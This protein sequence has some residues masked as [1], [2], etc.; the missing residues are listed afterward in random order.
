MQEEIHKVLMQNMG[1]RLTPELINGLTARL[2]LIGMNSV[3]M[4]VAA[5]RAEYDSA[6]REV[7]GND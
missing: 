5:V 2:D 3:N 7:A 6:S 4:A 1:N